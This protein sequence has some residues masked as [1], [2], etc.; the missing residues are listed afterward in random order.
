MKKEYNVREW[1]YLT[2]VCVGAGRRVCLC[3]RRVWAV[4]LR[5]RREN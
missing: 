4:A 5:A 2:E 3:Q 1:E